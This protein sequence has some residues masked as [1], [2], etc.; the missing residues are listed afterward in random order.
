MAY[1]RMDPEPFLPPGFSAMVVQHHEITSR[2]VSMRLP[3]MHE[4]LAIINI[5][6]L[7]GHEV[8]FPAVRDVVREY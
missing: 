2:S 7:L 8:L 6:P 4:D 5:H 1:Q 3:P